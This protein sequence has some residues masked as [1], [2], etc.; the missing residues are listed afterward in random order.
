LATQDRRQRSGGL[1]FE[2]SSEQ[3]VH[4]TLFHVNPSQKKEWWSGSSGRA[5][6]LSSNSSVAKKKKGSRCLISA[7]RSKLPKC[8][9]LQYFLQKKDKHE[10]NY[11][12]TTCHPKVFQKNHKRLRFLGMC[13]GMCL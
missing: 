5:P 1:R 11:S 10:E 13:G 7:Y 6:A 2:A 9:S 4:E 3:I 8:C 12:D